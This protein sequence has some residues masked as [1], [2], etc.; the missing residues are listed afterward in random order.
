MYLGGLDGSRISRPTPQMCLL[1]GLSADVPLALSQSKARFEKGCREDC[2][3]FL[4][5]L[6]VCTYE[7]ESEVSL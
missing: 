3:G 4:V 5:R 2:E 7:G 6:Y 1:H